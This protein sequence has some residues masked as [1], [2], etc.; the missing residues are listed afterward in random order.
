MA[1]RSVHRILRRAAWTLLALVLLLL[2]GGLYWL[3]TPQALEWLTRQAIIA[4]EGRLAI[5]GAQGSLYSRINISRV[6]YKDAALD[7]EARSVTLE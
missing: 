5:E 6:A 1:S 2:G 4:G 7:L 3:G